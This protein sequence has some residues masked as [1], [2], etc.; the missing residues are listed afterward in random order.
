MSWVFAQ[1]FWSTRLYLPQ[2]IACSLPTSPYNETHFADPRFAELIAAAMPRPR[3]G[4][5]VRLPVI[6]A[7][8]RDVAD[9]VTRILSPIADVLVEANV[10]PSVEQEA[11]DGAR[12]RIHEL[13]LEHVMRQAPGFAGLMDMTDADIM[14]T[15][16]AVGHMLQ[17][18][19]ARDR[20]NVLCVDIGGATTDVFSVV[21]GRFNRTV[22][23]NLG[24]SYSAAN[25][26]AE[27]GV[28]NIARWVDVP[29]GQLLN[30]ILNKTVR[31]TTI[32]ETPQELAI[33]QALAR[34][35]LRLAFAQ[36]R[37]FSIGMKG[38]VTERAIDGGFS[39]GMAEAVSPARLDLIIGSGGVL[40][41]A[42]DALQTAAMVVDAFAPEGLTRIARDSIF[43][44]PHLGVL[45]RENEQAAMD[46]FE[47]DCIAE[48]C[49]CVAPTGAMK[50]GT[51]LSFLLRGGPGECRGSVR[52]GELLRV[53]LPPGE[54]VALEV[55]PAGRLDAGAGPGRTVTRTLRAGQLGVIFDCRGR[56]FVP[57]RADA[58]RAL[59]VRDAW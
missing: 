5:N 42:P 45:S 33:E 34:E 35:A 10:R 14:P 20:C 32:P 51:A 7:G 15:P 28:S 37:E 49:L 2:A 11:V 8:N 22:S 50:R 1:D 29:E 41:H 13:F 18:I 52:A 59:P 47:R 39:K 56:P 57:R 58:W 55:V 30:E 4:D 43:M 54:T 38:G 48:L 25:V 31:P 19:S 53:A 6:F 24:M 44:L 27:T 16:S 46:V 23:A 9:E 36:H 12:D 40:S 3:L 17:L 26:L 21:D